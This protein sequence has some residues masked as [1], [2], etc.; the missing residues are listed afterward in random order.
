MLVG[1][2]QILALVAKAASEQL[3]EKV[4]LMSNCTDEK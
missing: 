3:S 4:K 1:S 2:Q